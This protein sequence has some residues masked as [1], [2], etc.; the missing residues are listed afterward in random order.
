[1]VVAHEVGVLGKS[2]M[3][4]LNQ[5]IMVMYHSKRGPN[6]SRLH[7]RSLFSTAK[8]AKVLEN[9]YATRTLLEYKITTQR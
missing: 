7:L 3:L 9:L 1:M 6:L 4:T 8:N 5:E 2:E